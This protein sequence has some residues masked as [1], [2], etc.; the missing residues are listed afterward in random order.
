MK[1]VD[2]AR[3][4]ILDQNNLVISFEYFAFLRVA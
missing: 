2:G 4:P 3:V 1:S